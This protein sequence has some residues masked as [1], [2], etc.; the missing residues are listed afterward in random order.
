MAFRGLSLLLR[1]NLLCCREHFTAV[2]H[3]DPL[4][5]GAYTAAAV[6]RPLLDAQSAGEAI[7]VQ[8]ATGQ[9]RTGEVAGPQPREA[10]LMP[11][12]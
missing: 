8:C 7:V 10:G 12:S 3:V 11:T 9:A 2:V 5:Q 6:L 4:S 1:M